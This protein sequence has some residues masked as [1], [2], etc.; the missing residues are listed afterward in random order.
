MGRLLRSNSN[1]K[2]SLD[3]RTPSTPFGKMQ[4]EA[5]AGNWFMEFL[6]KA[7]ENG[8]KKSKGTTD[9]NANK[10]PQSLILKVINWV[11]VE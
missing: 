7:L 8:M 11:E 5:V 1:P 3:K 2:V 6:K 10:V 9:G 4:L